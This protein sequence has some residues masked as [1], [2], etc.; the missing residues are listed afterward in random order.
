[1]FDSIFKFGFR[2]NI[3][4]IIKIHKKAPIKAKKY[5]KKSNLFNK[6]N[7]E[8]PLKKSL[9]QIKEVLHREFEDINYVLH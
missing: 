5:Q 4:L 2:T 6:K 9:S 8:I 7:R 3:F 1:V